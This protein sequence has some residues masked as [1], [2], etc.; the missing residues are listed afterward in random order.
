MLSMKKKLKKEIK[1]VFSKFYFLNFKQQNVL[2]L[3]RCIVNLQDFFKRAYASD[4]YY[5]NNLQI[6][7]DHCYGKVHVHKIISID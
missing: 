4:N 3:T 7:S 1:Q 6:E 5:N 2:I